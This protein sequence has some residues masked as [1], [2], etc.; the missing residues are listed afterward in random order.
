MQDGDSVGK[1][2]GEHLEEGGGAAG[3]PAHH[4]GGLTGRIS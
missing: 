4:T 3:P 2:E 1:G